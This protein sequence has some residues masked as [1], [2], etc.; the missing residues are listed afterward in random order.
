[1]IPNTLILFLE[2][3][4]LQEGNG[5]ASARNGAALN[6]QPNPMAHGLW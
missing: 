3:S 4:S 6:S 2:S 5:Q 1:M